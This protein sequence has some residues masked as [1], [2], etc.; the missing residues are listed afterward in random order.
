MALGLHVYDEMSH[1]FLDYYN[2]T[3]LTLYGHFRG[4]PRIDLE[5]C[6]WLG[7][8]AVL[9]LA[10]LMLTPLAFRNARGLP[11]LAY[12]FA[13]FAV[14]EGLEQVARTVREAPGGQSDFDG[15]SPGFYTAPLLLVRSAY[16]F[17][18]LRR[19][20]GNLQRLSNG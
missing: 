3:D 9:L 2:A 4:F 12:S 8:W 6:T 18:S 5:S 10:L 15:V 1:N 14:L 20:A 17:E 16:L 11:P 7:G 19:S 13:A